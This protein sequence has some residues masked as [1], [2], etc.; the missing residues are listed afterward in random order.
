MKRAWPILGACLVAS[1]MLTACSSDESSS[2]VDAGASS[3][4]TPAPT[5]GTPSGGTPAPLGGEPAPVGGTPAPV[6]GEPAPVG[7][8]P[9][10][11]GGEPAPVGGTPAPVGGEPA[12]VG[13][14]PAPVGGEP[15]PAGGEPAPVGGAPSPAGPTEAEVAAIFMAACNG[16]HIGGT[17]G[18]L[19]LAGDFT[20]ATVNVASRQSGLDLIEPG[21][22]AASYLY[23]KV[24][25]TH[26]EA[27]GR[28]SR[29]PLGG[30]LSA[31]EIETIGLWIDSL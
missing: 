10:P 22:R 6:G 27:G 17:S 21:D 28:S 25:G 4:G 7:G 14:E 31:G 12:P 24:E 26:I 5:G 16:C 2:S 13:G 18:G 9:A 29:M 3:G 23:R 30:A 19:S 1:T 11:V 8:T 15:A 20:Q